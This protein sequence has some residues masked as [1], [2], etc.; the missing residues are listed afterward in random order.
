MGGGLVSGSKEIEAMRVLHSKKPEWMPR[1]RGLH[2][3]DGLI[4]FDV[5][6]P[7]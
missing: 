6:S 3:L 5:L 2:R 4:R 7:Y 1:G